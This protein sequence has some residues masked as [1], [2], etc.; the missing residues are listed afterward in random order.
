[1]WLQEPASAPD[2][3]ATEDDAHRELPDRLRRPEGGG[4]MR[5][6]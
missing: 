4:V 1:M 3:L 5:M 6:P 2:V